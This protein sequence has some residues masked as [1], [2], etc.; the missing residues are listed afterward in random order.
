[1]KL[2]HT[3]DHI[4]EDVIAQSI[5][6]DGLIPQVA[7][8]YKDLVPENIRQLPVVWL[9]EG[10]WQGFSH[11]IFEVDSKDLDN[12]KLYR[13]NVVYD[14]DKELKWWVYQGFIPS[15]LISRVQIPSHSLL[16]DR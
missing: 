9:A 12:D 11:P 15:T 5:E 6:K 8:E 2:H 10:I 3:V 1:M 13:N 16:E 7:S 14:A 4:P